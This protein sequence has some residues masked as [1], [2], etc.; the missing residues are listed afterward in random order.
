[1]PSP[2]H[3]KNLRNKLKKKKYEGKNKVGG[4]GCDSKTK[5]TC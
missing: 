3:S 2:P 1:M 5:W 4:S